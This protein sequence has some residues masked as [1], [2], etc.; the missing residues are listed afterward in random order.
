MYQNNSITY[1]DTPI[2]T[3]NDLS[4]L[5]KSE[6][7]N[8]TYF[9]IINGNKIH[10]KDASMKTIFET[11]LQRESWLQNINVYTENIP[12]T[13]E[14]MLETQANLE[15]LVFLET[16][17]YAANYVNARQLLQQYLHSKYNFSD[18][19]SLYK[20]YIDKKDIIKPNEKIADHKTTIPNYKQKNQPSPTK[21]IRQHLCKYLSKQMNSNIESGLYSSKENNKRRFFL[22]F[23]EI[24]EFLLRFSFYDGRDFSHSDSQ[25]STEKLPTFKSKNQYS[26]LSYQIILEKTKE[27]YSSLSEWQPF[28]ISTL[29]RCDT[30][31]LFQKLELLKR[32]YTW[33]QSPYVY[34]KIMQEHRIPYTK[35]EQLK[36]ILSN[37]FDDKD[38]II[39][40]LRSKY[41]DFML[42]FDLR[43]RLLIY[44]VRDRTIGEEPIASIEET[45][46]QMKSETLAIIT[47]DLHLSPKN[48]FSFREN[49]EFSVNENESRILDKLKKNKFFN[50][51]YLN[52]ENKPI[53]EATGFPDFETIKKA[54]NIDIV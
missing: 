15:A 26:E 52:K 6:E 33:Y 24:P 2:Y 16:V 32:Y 25:E 9:K 44:N 40:G 37:I 46:K 41:L 14:D 45:L 21:S 48:I 5:V 1:K 28:E 36:K 22:P 19:I 49:G 50:C 8:K 53:K 54:V 34:D 29:Y 18:C 38:F 10:T 23:Y 42:P 17:K 31:F 3:I 12:Y 20:T 35:I 39:S 51:Y 4:E 47:S 11:M 30:I 27:L 7:Q 43:F 13:F